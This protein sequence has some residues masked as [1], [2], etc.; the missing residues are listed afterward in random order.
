MKKISP[1]IQVFRAVLFLLIL[2]FHCGVPYADFGWAGVETFFVISSFFMTRNKWDKMEIGGVIDVKR[3]FLHRVTRLYPPYSAVI[4]IAALY[5]FM[6]KRIPYDFIPHLLF[7][8]N[9]LWIASGYKSPMQPMTAHTWTMSIEVFL[10][11]IWLVLFKFLSKKQFKYAMYIALICGIIYRTTGTALNASVYT[12]SLCPVAHVD[13]FACGSLLA[14]SICE[15]T[16][17][18]K[19]LHIIG[20]TGLIGIIGCVFYIANS[21]GVSIIQGY[22]ML[23]SSQS[24][25]TSCFTCNIYLFITLFTLSILGFLY[26]R[27]DR[28]ESVSNWFINIMIR[29]GNNSY[30]LYLFHY[31]ILMVVK[32]FVGQYYITLPTVFA[33]SLVSVE[34]FNKSIFLIQKRFRRNMKDDTNI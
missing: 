12:I 16:T 24:Y 13:A 33:V 17:S 29:L 23:S 30:A 8:Q 9:F 10:G 34:I 19:A 14:A 11:L 18:K 25:L 6:T 5:V 2:A 31:P 1:Y 22:K 7:S 27:G 20:M 15:K 26:L 28:T 32:K 3:N 4:V 21:N